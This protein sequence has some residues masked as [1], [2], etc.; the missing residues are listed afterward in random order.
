MDRASQ[1]RPCAGIRSAVSNYLRRNNWM[2]RQDLY[3][4][5]A[6]EAIVAA[7]TWR[8]GGAPLNAYQASAVAKHLSAYITREASPL[9]HRVG[10]VAPHVERASVEALANVAAPGAGVEFSLDLA[11]A[12]R[13]VRRIMS[14]QSPAAQAVLLAERPPAEV[15][16]EHGLTA[17]QVYVEAQ[18]ARRALRRS[19]VLAELAAGL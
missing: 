10:H 6:L 1:D 17:A 7:Q 13:E 2:E 18:R 8:P 3:Q 9:H 15:A 16:R 19:P 12:A 14:L 5:A 11:R 4:Q